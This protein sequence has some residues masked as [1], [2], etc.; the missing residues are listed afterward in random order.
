MIKCLWSRV[1]LIL[2]VDFGV[3]IFITSVVNWGLSVRGFI[4]FDEGQLRIWGGTPNV[5]PQ[6]WRNGTKVGTEN[7]GSPK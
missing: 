2:F 1:S 5:F 6:M 7:E 3:L 4:E